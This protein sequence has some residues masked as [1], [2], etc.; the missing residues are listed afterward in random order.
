VCSLPLHPGLTDAEIDLVAAEVN[1]WQPDH[2]SAP[3]P[4]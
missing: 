4:R 3:A 2:P 1:A